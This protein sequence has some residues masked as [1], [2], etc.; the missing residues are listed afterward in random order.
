V[1]EIRLTLPRRHPGQQQVAREAK[2]W[3]VLQC[4]RRWGKTT[5]GTDLLIEPALDGYPSAWFAPTYKLLAEVWRVAASTLAPAT[6]SSNVQE[7]RIELVTGGVIDFWSLDD[8]DPPAAEV[9]T[10]GGR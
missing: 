7:K 6:R 10:G 9:Q 5:F 8:A 4:G 2:R 3:N 1:P